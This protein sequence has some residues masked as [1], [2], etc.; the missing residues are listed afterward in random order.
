MSMSH[1]ERVLAALNHREPDRVPLDLGSNRNTGI[2]I[3][4]YEALV[5][6]L[7]LG[8]ERTEKDDFGQSKVARI[9]TPSEAV[10]QRLDVDFRGIFLGLPDT[11]LERMLPD[12][13]HQD[14]LGVVRHRPSSS[15]YYDIV[16]SPFDR[17]VTVADIANWNWPD[18]TDPGYVRGMREKATVL[19]ETTDYA[20]VFH[21][22]DII[23]HPS[24]YMRGFERWFMDFILAPDLMSALLD[25]ILEIRT[26]LTV[27]A[28]EQVG[29]LVDVVS[30]SDDVADQRGPQISPDMYRKFIKP[31]HQKYFDAIRSHT[32]AKILYHSC[33][34]VGRL[35]P[36]FIDMGVDFLNPVQ[37]SANGM[38]TA[39]LKREYGDRIGFWGAV[40]TM[41]VLPFGTPDEVKAEVRKRIHDLAPGGGFVLSAVHNIQPQVPPQ[42]I[43][44]MF[45]AARELGGYPI[46]V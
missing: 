40:D 12:G 41:R 25:A 11:P 18:P 37:V 46:R 34:A 4:P 19:R 33:G 21:T 15:Y 27:A 5:E 39:W 6:Y 13:S 9:A 45:D 16:Y 35:I 24:Q 8:G 17:E 7:G 10:L 43:V 23:V 32:S 38:D 30:C 26:E 14:E 1:R 22:Q 2:L 29:D 3:E 31:R 42:N 28:L 20:L 36:D 44:A